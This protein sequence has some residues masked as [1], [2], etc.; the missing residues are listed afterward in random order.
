MIYLAVF[1]HILKVGITQTFRKRTRWLE[2]G[3]DFAAE[4][5]YATDGLLARKIESSISKK[6]RITDR[7]NGREK[8]SMLFSDPNISLSMLKKAIEMLH[9]PD[10]VIHDFR[11]SYGLE[12]IRSEPKLVELGKGK[13]IKGK[14]VAVK[15][16]LVVIESPTG[17][18]AIN[19]HS[20]KGRMVYEE[21]GLSGF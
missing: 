11:G 9:I 17:Y 10:Y 3:A 18:E 16:N 1:G 8:L 6:I 12:N 13:I 7:V 5:G 2:Q 20:L 15:G 4:I 19:L 21:N 14:V